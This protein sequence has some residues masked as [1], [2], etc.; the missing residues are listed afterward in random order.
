MRALP[1]GA[2][3]AQRSVGVTS[4]PCTPFHLPTLSGAGV[5]AES[6]IPTFRGVGGLWRNRIEEEVVVI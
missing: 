1:Q 2:I 3:T 5:S 4:H 6:G